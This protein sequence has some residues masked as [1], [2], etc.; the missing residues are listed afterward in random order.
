M[1]GGLVRVVVLL[2]AVVAV[3]RA[4]TWHFHGKPSGTW[5]KTAMAPLTQYTGKKWFGVG[6]N[7]KLYERYQNNNGNWYWVDHGKPT[8]DFYNEG[9]SS[10]KKSGLKARTFV[11]HTNG[12]LYERFWEWGTGWTLRYHGRP[13]SA[14][15]VDTIKT[16]SYVATT[17]G[18]SNVFVVAT[19][20]NMYRRWTHQNGGSTWF[21]L[22]KP[23]G[24]VIRSIH[25]TRFGHWWAITTDGSV[26]RYQGGWPCF[27]LANRRILDCSDP[28]YVGSGKRSMFCL[29]VSEVTVTVPEA[30]YG[31]YQ[32]TVG[33]GS[34][35]GT[36]V[37]RNLPSVLHTFVDRPNVAFT[38]SPNWPVIQTPK[39]V[40]VSSTNG[41]Y[42]LR[43]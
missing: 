43:F 39:S 33:W 14:T 6:S 38:S 24:K 40:F 16:T 7:G 10:V 21:N 26:C 13:F 1:A 30:G 22:G 12:R 8:N 20:G 34:S 28:F 37:N 32:L 18:Y 4:Q 2:C 36:W 27:S 35:T 42:E 25:A 41:V 29:T 11:R 31:L 3:T 15:Y 23:A 17:S 19:N 5:I 9:C